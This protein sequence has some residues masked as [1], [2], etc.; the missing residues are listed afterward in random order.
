MRIGWDLIV[1]VMVTSEVMFTHFEAIS[2]E[3]ILQKDFLFSCVCTV[4][5]VRQK[6]KRGKKV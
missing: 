6:L 5:S 2:K 1:I 3:L 4:L